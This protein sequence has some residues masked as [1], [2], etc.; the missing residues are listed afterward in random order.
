MVHRLCTFHVVRVR[1]LCVGGVVFA[2]R[3]NWNS[4][5][6]K[7]AGRKVHVQ[8]KIQIIRSS[9]SRVLCSPKTIRWHNMWLCANLNEQ[10]RVSK[11]NSSP[12]FGRQ[13]LAGIHK[14]LEKNPHPNRT[15]ELRS[16]P[17]WTWTHQRNDQNMWFNKS[18]QSIETCNAIRIISKTMHCQEYSRS[19]ANTITSN[20][21]PK[22]II[23]NE[24]TSPLRNKNVD[25]TR[26]FPC[27]VPSHQQHIH[28]ELN[29][30]R[31]FQKILTTIIVGN[32]TP[33]LKPHLRDLN[34]QTRKSSENSL[35]FWQ[36]K[37]GSGGTQMAI[38]LMNIS[39]IRVFSNPAHLFPLKRWMRHR[40]W[41]RCQDGH[42]RRLPHSKGQIS[43]HTLIHPCRVWR[44]WM[45]SSTR[46]L[47]YS[48]STKTRWRSSDHLPTKTT[49]LSHSGTRV[50]S[51]LE[52][53]DVS[54]E[55]PSTTISGDN[56]PQNQKNLSTLPARMTQ[57]TRPCSYSRDTQTN[58]P[59][60]RLK[61]GLSQTN[62]EWC[63]NLD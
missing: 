3:R 33:I 14:V 16:N 22:T 25:E 46:R 29:S 24:P 52:R 38:H 35:D 5:R 1:H 28:Y 60:K 40:N 27:H 18:H 58:V 9:P 53:D 32:K 17:A 19:P 7:L 63:R 21:E 11:K 57:L 12:R 31:K 39:A 55:I 62:V 36:G 45:T 56:A 48:F 61:K 51:T 47:Q 30:T 43:L 34:R 49:E 59:W 50:A 4:Q 44:N 42:E 41:C 13:K 54:Q 26:M 20:S 2:R 10:N 23:Q 6:S 37:I 15:I 8:P